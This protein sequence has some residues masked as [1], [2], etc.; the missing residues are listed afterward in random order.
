[1]RVF[2]KFS[3][4]GLEKIPYGKPLVFAP[5]HVNAFIDPV[6]VGM[7]ARQKVRF[8]ARGD[9]FKR[10][11]AKWVLD[12]MNISPMYRIQE[13]YA[14]L[15]KNDKTFEE[16]RRL[17]AANKAI[18]LFPEAI[19][20]QE[21]R[22]RPLKK[23]LARIIFQT[24]ET[25]DFKKDVLVVPVGLN[26]SNAKQFRS[27]LFIDFGD[28]VSVKEYEERYKQ[29][30]V[31]TINDFTKIFE[32]KLSEHL[33][34]IKDPKNDEL[35][36]GIEEIYLQQW[37]AD[38]KQNGKKLEQHYEA[39]KEIAD[40]VNK[41]DEKN[42]EVTLLLKEKITSYIE[43]L[44]AGKLRDHLLRPEN[45]DKMNI[46]MFL[47]EYM[48]IYFGMPIYTLCLLFNYPPFYIAKKL[49]DK[50]IKNV[51]FYASVY[52]NTAMIIWML[53]YGTALLLIAL[54]FHNWWLVLAYAIL[55]PLSGRFCLRFYPKMKKIFG[56]WRLLRM[57]R[58]ERS[59][60]EELV[61]AREE[62][63]NNLVTAKEIYITALK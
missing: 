31:R 2:Y 56:R 38:K 29:D 9:V 11:L 24:E 62:I 22:L 3:Y 49:S 21:R 32:Q 47:W 60:V 52:S 54:L 51:E 36:A 50:K 59:T 41:L 1:M 48:I 33:I 4:R 34:I 61:N 53:L 15:K 27:K 30:K 40:M 57:V 35:V 20:I 37:M 19:C 18:L 6:V 39:S 46:G 25:F 58:K 16:C 13:G 26:Y 17:L 8:F 44:K 43:K 5:N 42:P 10:G 14:E 12:Q 7:V 28:P 55:F 45:I 63:I 23:G